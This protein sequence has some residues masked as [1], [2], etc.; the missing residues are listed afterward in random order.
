MTMSPVLLCTHISQWGAWMLANG[1]AIHTHICGC[2]FRK[3]ILGAA[4]RRLL[5]IQGAGHHKDKLSKRTLA[6]EVPL[7][8]TCDSLV[9]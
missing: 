7:G 6:A 1:N 2:D 3:A 5:A 8:I 9:G 4:C